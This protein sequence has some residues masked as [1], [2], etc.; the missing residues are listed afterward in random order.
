MKYY[1]FCLKHFFGINGL[2]HLI[3]GGLDL[4]LAVYLPNQLKTELSSHCP[5]LDNFYNS[6][7]NG[8][9]R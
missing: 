6:Q 9:I 2:R 4:F 1:K 8:K 3:G 7:A 5:F